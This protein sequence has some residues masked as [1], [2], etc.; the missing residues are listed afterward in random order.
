MTVPIRLPDVEGALV[1]GLKEA[2]PDLHV[3]DTL[4]APYPAV[5]FAAV[6]GPGVLSRVLL[7]LFVQ[8][9]VALDT[10][11]SKAACYG[12]MSDVL[13]ACVALSERTL[14]GAVI[15]RVGLLSSP[16][17]LP[18]PTTGAPRYVATLTVRARSAAPL[19]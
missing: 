4:G 5:R 1:L 18:D 13:T 12:T 19:G 3:G 7:D 14:A 17:Y 9:D 8:V 2:R 15:A 11:G 10:G 6:G 16:A